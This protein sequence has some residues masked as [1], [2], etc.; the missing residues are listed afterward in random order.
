MPF[1]LSICPHRIMLI[2]QSGFALF[3]LEPLHELTV[4]VLLLGVGLLI[5]SY[6]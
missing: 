2:C 3:S 5:A 4:V 6:R 1:I